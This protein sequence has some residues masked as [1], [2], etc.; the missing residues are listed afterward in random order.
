MSNS[1]ETQAVRERWA[2]HQ[3]LYEKYS[4]RVPNFTEIIDGFYM[5]PAALGDFVMAVSSFH[6]SRR[7]YADYMRIYADY[8]R[9]YADYMRIYCAYK[10][11]TAFTRSRSEIIHELRVHGIK[12]ILDLDGNYLLDT[13]RPSLDVRGSKSLRGF[14]HIQT[15]RLLCPRHC[16]R[17]FDDDPQYVLSF[18]GRI[19]MGTH[20]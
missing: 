3:K 6:D 18:I 20:S 9:I 15:A 14:H 2:Y 19:T 5:N 12:Y 10:V 4:A 16:L 8:M 11:H 17:E 7:I 1:N 13:F